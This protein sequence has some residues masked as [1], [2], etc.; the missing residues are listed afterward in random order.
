MSSILY[1]NVY[2]EYFLLSICGNVKNKLLRGNNACILTTNIYRNLI[3]EIKMEGKKTN[4]IPG[5][6]VTSSQ[7]ETTNKTE[8]GI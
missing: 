3:I 8:P 4:G 5:E 2:E 1:S 6:N 7:K